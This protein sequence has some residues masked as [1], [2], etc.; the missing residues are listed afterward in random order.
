MFHVFGLVNT[1]NKLHLG[2]FHCRLCLLHC[3]H[4]YSIDDLNNEP[5]SYPPPPHQGD[6]TIE[7]YVEKYCG[8][9]PG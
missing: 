1:V 8:L 5:S 9:S 3:Q 6:R 2:S 7:D 4:R